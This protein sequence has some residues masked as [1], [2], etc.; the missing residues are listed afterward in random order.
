MV[1]QMDMMQENRRLVLQVDPDSALRLPLTVAAPPPLTR[2]HPVETEHLALVLR[3]SALALLLAGHWCSCAA[4]LARWSPPRGAEDRVFDQALVALVSMLS[5][6]QLLLFTVGLI[7]RARLDSVRPGARSGLATGQTSGASRCHAAPE[8]PWRWLV[9]RLPGILGIGLA[10]FL[11]LTWAFYM[12]RGYDST[13]TDVAQYHLPYALSYAQGRTP[14]GLAVTDAH[15]PQSNSVLAALLLL[16]T[17]SPLLGQLTHLLILPL[18]A[19]SMAVLLREA[20]VARAWNWAPWVTLAL[21]AMPMVSGALTLSADLPFAV[22]TIALFVML[23]RV[24]REGTLSTRNAVLLTAVAGYLLASKSTGLATLGIGLALLGAAVLVRWMVRGERLHWPQH[25]WWAL[26]GSLTALFVL[27]GVWLLRNW[28]LWGSPLS[29]M[30]VRIGETWLFS[31]HD[32]SSMRHA[33]SVLADVLEVPNYDYPARFLHYATLWFAPWIG[34]LP[35]IALAVAVIDAAE[36]AWQCR[37]R[38]EASVLRRR[39]GLAIAALLF[40]AP[41]SLIFPSLPW[42]SLENYDGLSLRY[43]LPFFLLVSVTLAVHVFLLSL[44]WQEHPWIAIAVS[45]CLLAVVLWGWRPTR[46]WPSM[47]LAARENDSLPLAGVAV[48]GAALCTW[49]RLARSPGRQLANGLIIGLLLLVIGV[50]A[51][52]A[53]SGEVCARAPTGARTEGAR[54]AL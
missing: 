29:P 12:V 50:W 48:L 24:W 7:V 2:W 28:A 4:L 10:A 31:G 41:H 21:L 47:F 43:L 26:G 8:H 25:R 40:A 11:M 33:Y 34:W 15:Y 1:L 49:R 9:E 19:A 45:L 23:W 38:Q 37:L 35:P 54:T 52:T 32:P 14:W 27:G 3:L 20:G 42:T 18:L 16:A 53:A 30:G 51:N 44:R 22:A 17:G 5:L 39:L 46:F 13:G 36:L 6:L